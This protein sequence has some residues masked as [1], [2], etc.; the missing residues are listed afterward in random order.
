[1]T[2]CDL[3]R[4]APIDD[5]G[6]KAMF[7]IM[8]YEDIFL[9][10]VQ[11][12]QQHFGAIG[13]SLAHLEHCFE[14]F[15]QEHA[16]CREAHGVGVQRALMILRLDSF[17][18]RLLCLLASFSIAQGM[19]VQELHGCAPYVSTKNHRLQQSFAL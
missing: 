15:T 4:P 8:L 3:C 2:F 12:P 6:D 1:M 7:C 18:D 11:V 5:D 17:F 10:G 14:E 9:I 16:S 13:Q 19:D